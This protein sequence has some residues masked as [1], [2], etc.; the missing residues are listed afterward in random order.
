MGMHC[1]TLK[2]SA[3]LPAL[4]HVTLKFT[5][6]YHV[7]YKA[8]NSLKHIA[9]LWDPCNVFRTSASAFSLQQLAKHPKQKAFNLSFFSKLNQTRGAPGLQGR[10]TGCLDFFGSCWLTSV[11]SMR[12]QKN[13]TSE[14][15]LSAAVQRYGLDGS[16]DL[17]S[18]V[19]VGTCQ[20]Q[21][22]S[23]SAGFASNV[24]V[25]HWSEH[26]FKSISCGLWVRWA[27]NVT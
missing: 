26:K 21:P 13:R 3:R 9:L 6:T 7:I 27:N 14:L 17:H 19:H 4:Q 10:L 25:L 15:F 2:T 11:S 22:L 8:S 5:F 18:A 16:Q 20:N 12:K 1:R 23:C 24:S